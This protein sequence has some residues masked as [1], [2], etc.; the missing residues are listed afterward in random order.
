M[1]LGVRGCV[2]VVIPLGQ[3]LAAL[4]DQNRPDVLQVKGTVR[5]VVVDH[6]SER[7]TRQ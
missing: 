7:G 1:D 3:Q 6:R 5:D 2:A 4:A